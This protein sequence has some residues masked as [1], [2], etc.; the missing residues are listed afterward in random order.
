MVRGI[1][2]NDAYMRQILFVYTK[3]AK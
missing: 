3:G 1:I 2:I